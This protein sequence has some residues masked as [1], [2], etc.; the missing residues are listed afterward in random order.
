MGKTRKMGRKWRRS[1]HYQPPAEIEGHSQTNT[2]SVDTNVTWTGRWK[3]VDNKLLGYGDLGLI[4]FLRVEHQSL[5]AAKMD[6]SEIDRNGGHNHARWWIQHKL[7]L[8][9]WQ[10]FDFCAVFLVEQSVG[11]LPCSLCSSWSCCKL[12]FFLFHFLD[13]KFR[14]EGAAL[15]S[16]NLSV[17]RRGCIS[18]FF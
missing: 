3:G 16:W 18:R 4:W 7:K 13:A 6:W 5:R 10:R 2:T 12:F 9:A 11:W 17:W 8:S 14:V 15:S 1:R